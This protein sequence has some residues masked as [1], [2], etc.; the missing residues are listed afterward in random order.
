MRIL[1]YLLLGVLA[2]LIL[3]FGI[4]LLLPSSYKVERSQTIK[5]PKAEVF[6]LVGDL[7]NWKKWSPWQ[8]QMPDMEITYGP[9]TDAKGGW[10]SWKHESGNGKMVITAYRPTDSVAFNLQFEGMA[11][12]DITFLF[13]EQESG[14]RVSWKM[15]GDLG[16]NPLSN[17]VA[18]MMDQMVGSDFEEGLRNLKE[19][20]EKQST[21]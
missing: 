9:V 21:L 15:S 16:G 4:A 7:K 1:R 11:P 8:E 14:T 20:A 5:A 17:Y 10:Y 13:E 19:K 18:A 3:V 2:A 6:Q 12:A